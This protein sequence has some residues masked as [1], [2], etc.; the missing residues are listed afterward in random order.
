MT[1]SI[2]V[3]CYNEAKNIPLILSRFDQVMTRNDVEVL[4]VNNG[5]TDDSQ[6]VFDERV[7]TYSFA[8]VVNVPVNKGYGYGIRQGLDAATGDIIGWTHADMQTDPNDVIMAI[9]WLSSQP[10]QSQFFVKGL[11]KGRPIF[12]QFFTIGMSVFEFFLLGKPL[13]DINAQPNLFSKS[14]YQSW[15]QPPDDF[16][17]DLYAYYQAITQGLSI[18]RFD[19]QF[20]ERLHGESHWN[21]SLGAKFKFIKRAMSFSLSLKKML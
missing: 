21:T 15:T 7:P 13:W 18:K 6:A 3:P 12:D 8:R 9:D 5:S 16:A 1:Y 17:L 4:L 2:V 11:R 14:F 19:V 10:D 20:P